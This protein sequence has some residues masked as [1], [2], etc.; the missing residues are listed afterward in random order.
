MIYNSISDMFVKVTDK[1][2]SKNLYYYKKND[3]WVGL[4][5]K[6]IRSSVEFISFGIKSYNIEPQS[7]IAIMSN[8]SPRWAMACP[9]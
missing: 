4:S 8:N 3:N 2:K 6:Y 9:G 1:H 7:K 5:G